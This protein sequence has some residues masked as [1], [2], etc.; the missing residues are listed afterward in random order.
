M[1]NQVQSGLI[2]GLLRGVGQQ[3]KTNEAAIPSSIVKILNSLT[4]RERD[5]LLWKFGIGTPRL[6]HAHSAERMNVTSERLRQIQQRAIRKLTRPERLRIIT[7]YV[8]EQLN[9]PGDDH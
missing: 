9:A 2:T 8:S 3:V 1:S 7:S 6:T 4:D 5:S